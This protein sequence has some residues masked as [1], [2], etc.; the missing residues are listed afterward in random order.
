MLGT[1]GKVA[2]KAMKNNGQSTNISGIIYDSAGNKI[3][4]FKSVHAGMGSFSLLPEKDN[5]YY[6]ICVNDSG[7]SKRFDLPTALDYGYS[8]S[9]NCLVKDRVLVSVLQST[10]TIR[11]DEL[12]L[13]AHTRGMVHFVH[14]WDFTKNVLSLSKDNFP[15]GIMHLILFDSDLNPVSERLVFI[16]NADQ[17]Q[18]ICQSDRTNFTSRSLVNTTVTVTDNDGLPL[19]GS[20][21]VSITSDQ[22]VETDSTKNILTQLLLSSDLRGYIENPAYYFQNTTASAWMLDL[23]MCTQ[24]WRRYPVSEMAKGIFTEPTYP[25]EVSTEISGLVKNGMTGKPVEKIKVTAMSMKNGY[26]DVTQ[27]NKYGRFVFY[28]SELPDSALLVVSASPKKGIAKMML[29][30]E[31]ETF[32]KVSLSTIPAK[33]VDRKL[34]A[35]YA[36]MTEQKYV[37]ENGIRTI[38]L[39]EVIITTEKKEKRKSMFYSNPNSSFT[40]EDIE[41]LSSIP[42]VRELLIRM[43]GVFVGEKGSI[44]IRQFG[45]PLLVVDDVPMGIDKID[46]INPY[47][48]DQIDILA[49]ASNTAPFGMQGGNG[50]IV[51]FPKRGKINNE[52]PPLFHVQTIKPLGYQSPVEFY[53]PRYDT[54]DKKSNPTPDLRTTIHWQPD[55]RTDSLGMASFE[56]YTADEETSYTIIIEG[57]TDDGRIIRH[58]EKLWKK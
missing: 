56:F 30:I 31:E 48:I 3:V 47:D 28:N 27:T 54:P 2:F 51:I 5:N 10:E 1:T 34:F 15:S 45:T 24:G 18:T 58:E 9:V 32:P 42:D 22:V 29:T 19:I 26:I 8:L 49:N 33:D 37:F 36:K 52:L 13:L 57:L 14:V 50:V 53:A 55:V 4:E 11:Q 7:E 40:R 12:Y 25:L 39:P 46:V 17:A 38:Q 20:F 44:S 6:A 16:N 43:P 41:S 35:Q 23:L 21:S